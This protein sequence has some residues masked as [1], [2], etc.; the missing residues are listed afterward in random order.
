MIKQKFGSD[1]MTKNHLANVNEILCKVLCHNLCC[2]ISAYYELNVETSFC[3]QVP[4]KVKEVL[5]Y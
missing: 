1:L 2:L 3:T 5:V 4:E